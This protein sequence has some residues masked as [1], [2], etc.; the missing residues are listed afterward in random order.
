MSSDI[1]KLF[2][3]F[4]HSYGLIISTNK[5]RN[6]YLCMLVSCL[7]VYNYYLPMHSFLNTYIIALIFS[8]QGGT[9]VVHGI[10]PTTS[11]EFSSQFPM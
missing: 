8:F 11:K 2:I 7:I 10:M 5:L 1:D 4:N 3:K 9:I 6:F